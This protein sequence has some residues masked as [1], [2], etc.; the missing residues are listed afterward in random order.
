MRKAQYNNILAVLWVV[1]GMSCYAIVNGLLK[2]LGRQ[3]DSQALMWP[4]CL[5]VLALIAPWALRRRAAAIR[6]RKP[7]LHAL[8]AL[9]NTLSAIGTLYAL[10]HLTLGEITVYQLTTPIWLI[11]LAMLFLGEAVRP[12]RWLGVLVGF[13]GVW[14][15]ASPDVSQGVNLAVFVALACAIS[16]ALLGVLLKQ[17][18]TETPLAIVW[19]TYAGKATMFGLLAGFT[20]PDFTMTGWALLGLT[21]MVNVGCMLCFVIGYRTADAT[22]AETGSFAGL[23]VGPMAGW[24]MFGET[25]GPQFWLGS[26][27][28]AAGI[29][30]ALFE[31]NLK[32]TWRWRGAVIAWTRISR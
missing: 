22:I 30:I 19:W 12:M 29:L 6:T 10:K 16:D 27:V 25:L 20:V 4:L 31:P 9:F 26:A 7:W 11:P 5:A 15:V 3:Y 1:A 32:W 18:Q 24:L 21:A 13:A 17:G 2:Q 8:R 14:L 28:L 23:L